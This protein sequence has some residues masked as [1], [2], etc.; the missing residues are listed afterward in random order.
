MI[1]SCELTN[2]SDN[3]NF[4]PLTLLPAVEVIT[5]LPSNTDMVQTHDF[6]TEGGPNVDQDPKRYNPLI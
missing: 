4:K 6:G 2:D 3:F 5:S 1:I